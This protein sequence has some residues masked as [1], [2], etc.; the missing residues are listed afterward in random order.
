MNVFHVDKVLRDNSYL[1]SFDK[2]GKIISV[3]ESTILDGPLMIS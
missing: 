3:M 2:N 1:F